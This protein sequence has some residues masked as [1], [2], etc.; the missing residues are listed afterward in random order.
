MN[1]N[2]PSKSN[3][4][5]DELENLREGIT[6]MKEKINE[7]KT[8]VE[9]TATKFGNLTAVQQRVLR[10]YAK[11]PS[12]PVSTLASEANVPLSYFTLIVERYGDIIERVTSDEMDKYLDE[13]S[14]GSKIIIHDGG[15]L[16]DK[17]ADSV[18]YLARNL[19]AT[20]QEVA[21]AVGCSASYPSAVRDEYKDLIDSLA[22][23]YDSE[24]A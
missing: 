13:I 1:E 21:E 22:T 11:N 10:A 16:T 17:K 7:Q 20:N 6:S 14:S 24:L 23:S 3:D 9:D 12:G 2:N 19:N 18:E 8:E 15:K 4:I 5:S